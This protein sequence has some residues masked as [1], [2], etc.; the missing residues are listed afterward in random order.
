MKTEEHSPGGELKHN[1]EVRTAPLPPFSLPPGLE[2]VSCCSKDTLCARGHP[3]QN[4]EVNLYSN[5]F[6]KYLYLLR[7][8]FTTYHQFDYY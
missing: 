8:L 2:V 5:M 3:P 1:R 7:Q 6:V 4:P